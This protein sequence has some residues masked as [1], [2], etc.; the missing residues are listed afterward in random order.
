MTEPDVI[1]EVAKDGMPVHAFLQA[2][3]TRLHCKRN[4][5]ICRECR[6]N[7]VPLAPPDP[8]QTGLEAMGKARDLRWRDFYR[9]YS[10][11]H[12]LWVV[13]LS[14][15]SAQVI[16]LLF[17]GDDPSPEVVLAVGILVADHNARLGAV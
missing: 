11:K 16:P 6:T 3:G 4:A 8:Y 10:G 9:A 1:I 5:S 17:F 12:G 2:N 7:G 13:S 15:D 14:D